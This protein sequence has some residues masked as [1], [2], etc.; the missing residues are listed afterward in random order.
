VYAQ[1]V[2]RVSGGA[3]PG[4][5]VDVMDARGNLLGRGLYSPRSAIVVRLYS[6]EASAFDAK[7]LGHRIRRALERRAALGLPR[8][9]TTGF[10]LIHA[11][12]DDLPG[13]IVDRFGDVL[14]A[15]LGTLGMKLRENLIWD[16]LMQALA[17]RAL[18]DRTSGVVAKAEGFEPGSGVVRGDPSVN[19]LRFRELGFEYELPFGLG[20][21]TGYY[22]DQR[23]LR[24]RIRALSRGRRV[25]DTFA[26][27]GSLSLA[28]IAG[29]ASE[30]VAVD[31]SSLALEIAAD[32]AARNGLA[33]RIRYVNGDAREALD[34]AGRKGGYDLVI[35]DPP[36]L[37]P[38]RKDERRALDAMR[39]IAGAAAR[40]TRPGGWLALSSCSAAIGMT[41]L[42]RALAL[43][44]RDVG[45]RPTI[46][47][48]VYQGPDHPV[49]AAFPEGLY[50]STL[51]AELWP[52]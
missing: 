21:K 26:Y 14:V 22:F 35:C 20:Q 45:L 5:E 17:P 15:Q 30:A 42:S 6:R 46:L 48:R 52:V 18:V 11:E 25:L 1:A 33:G 9:D 49:P 39:R 12:G 40:A 29:G 19:A 38:S 32:A 13:L 8:D 47:E 28:A 50:L 31:S 24:E 27:V 41:E 16:A 37:A 36:K 23:P 10:R 44:A 7:L 43:G 34:E 51:I 3:T 2:E 4:D